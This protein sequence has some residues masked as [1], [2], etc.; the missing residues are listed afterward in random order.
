MEHQA[1]IT[2]LTLFITVIL[3]AVTFGIPRKYILLPFVIG[4]CWVPADQTI[5]VG[6][7][8]FQV[9]RVL[10]VMGILRLYM[11]SEVVRIRWNRFDKLVL[12]WALV[13][14]VIF[15]I[16]WMTLGAVINRCGRMLEWLGLYWVFRQSI[17]SWD[18][19]RLAHVAFAVCAIAM[20]PFVAHEWMSGTNPFSLL[21]RVT[22]KLRE[23]NYRCQSTFPH[24]IM[25]GLFWA[26]LVPLFVG[27]AKYKHKL[28]FWTAVGACVF[29]IAG[30]SSSTPILTLA[31]VFMLLLVYRWRK[32]TRAAAWGTVALIVVLQ[33]VM[34][35][36]VWHLLARISVVSG[37]TGWHR[38]S[39]ING[40]IR[41]FHEWMFVG[42]HSTGH[43][44]VG[45]QDITNQFILEGVRGGALTLALFCGI[46]FL[47][48]RAALRLSL[49]SR[50][51]EESFLAW[52]VFV[53][54]IG[55]CISF[56]GVSYFGQITMA[57]YLLLAG[58][59]LTYSKVHD[60]SPRSAKRAVVVTQPQ[61][62]YCNSA[63]H[64]H[65]QAYL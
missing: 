4:A 54:I 65:S 10:V 37:S 61:E 52:C 39:L 43:W 64:G 55:H 23:G 34:R 31:A 19:I 16:Q 12:A 49:Q 29:M 7:L 57:W 44:G 3:S 47:G 56:I 22:T 15:V 32:Y 40:A 5:M 46:L 27:F 62:V 36:P 9:L 11:R 53:T 60:K 58:A 24:A 1:T 18:D 21:G 38:Y 30:T 14:S 6:E 35:A 33:I 17:R 26:T 13:G 28:L 63:G 41:H 42:T 25:M 51:K 50:E 8:N 45:L 20:V 59:S 2:G 48:A